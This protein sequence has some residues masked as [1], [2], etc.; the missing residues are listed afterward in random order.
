M[1]KDDDWIGA[2]AVLGGLW[3]L[4]QIFSK[5][6]VDYF[7]CWNCNRILAPNTQVCPFC[8]SR[9]DWGKIS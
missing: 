6:K 3:L 8:K 4:G 1:G 9:I 2:L 5:K 7:K